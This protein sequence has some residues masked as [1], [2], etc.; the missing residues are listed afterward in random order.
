MKVHRL[1]FLLCSLPLFGIS[2]TILIRG[3]RVVDGTGA[4]ARVADVVVQGERIRSVGPPATPPR[5]A[6]VIDAKGKTLLPGLFDLHTHLRAS[7]SIGQLAPDWGKNL[8][9]YLASG[10][11][12][13]EDFSTYGEM[14][15]PMRRLLNTG[16]VHGP[17]VHLAVR[18][19]PPGGHGTESGWGDMFTLE[20]ATP[21]QAH[22][23]MREALPYKP[24]TIKIFTDGW[25]Y[26]SI[27]NLMSMNQETIAAIV[28]DAHQAHVKVLTHT[29]TLENARITVAA[30]VDALAHGTQ[31]HDVDAE[32]IDLMRKQGT[33][34]VSTLSVYEPRDRTKL[35]PGLESV[36][37]PAN[38][39]FL[40]HPIPVQLAESGSM[41]GRTKRWRTLLH[42]EKALFDAGIPLGN[43]TDS[44]IPG[45]FHGWASL[46]EL[47]LK[48]QAGLTPL[49]A[50]QAAT[51]N[52][53]RI[54]GVDQDMGSI[55]PG[56][57]A[58]L[59]LFSGKPDENIADIFT[60]ERVFVGGRAYDTAELRRDIASGKPTALPVHPLGAL[61]DDFERTDGRTELGTLRVNGTDPGID[62]SRI[63]FTRIARTASDHALMIQVQM[64]PKARNY[65]AVHFPLTPG[66]V[67]LADASPYQGISFDARGESG[68]VYTMRFDSYAVRSGEAFHAGFQAGPEWQT[69]HIAFTAL[70]RKGDPV[71]WTGKDLRELIVELS[72]PSLSSQW[73]EI[74]NLRFY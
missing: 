73:L 70:T 58:D 31:D 63:L 36:L 69:N 48:T 35:Y 5:G 53:A 59:V 21:Q 10:V 38:L 74:D 25:R 51:L 12:S 55:A 17:R 37:E 13:V 42:N 26:G 57:L 67:E 52:S 66:G 24:D 33:A 41:E 64:G 49:Q 8:E 61:I 30:G 6:R 47:Q 68:A 54:I 46:H 43:G 11:T 60:A 16:A 39:R 15:A 34:Y 56:K 7:A 19:S 44:G 18:M 29:V 2:Q 9:A 40:Q 4:P 3:A 45:T 27:P 62:H 28:Q 72:G 20:A 65:A 71:T 32:F 50:I 22:V 23:L 14:F 1:L